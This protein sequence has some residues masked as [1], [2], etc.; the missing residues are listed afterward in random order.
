MCDED[1]DEDGSGIRHVLVVT[2]A[3]SHHTRMLSGSSKLPACASGK[4][5]LKFLSKHLVC[6]AGS[7]LKLSVLA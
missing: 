3:G 4:P 2:C 7:G 6:R 1:C 5:E